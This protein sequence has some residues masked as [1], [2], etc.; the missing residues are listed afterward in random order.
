M[1]VISAVLDVRSGD[2]DIDRFDRSVVGSR[3]RGLNAI[4]YYIGMS[5]ALPGVALL[6]IGALVMGTDQF[7]GMWEKE[8]MRQFRRGDAQ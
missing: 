4:R 5:I 8:A 7:D 1:G 3:R 2:D 6:L